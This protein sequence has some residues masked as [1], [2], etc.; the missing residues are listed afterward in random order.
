M[1]SGKVYADVLSIQ[2]TPLVVDSAQFV[3]QPSGVSK[4]NNVFT[5]WQ[6]LADDYNLWKTRVAAPG[7]SGSNKATIVF[8]DTYAPISIPTLAGLADLDFASGTFFESIKASAEGS[9]STPVSI[10][11]GVVWNIEIDS[12]A[13]ARFRSQKITW[14]RE[15]PGAATWLRAPNPAMTAFEMLIQ[16]GGLTSASSSPVYTSPPGK[17]LVVSLRESTLAS[18]GSA[19]PL[20]AAAGAS[21]SLSALQQSSVKVGALSS[22]GPISAL[23]SILDASSQAGPQSTLV[24]PDN[25]ELNGPAAS[26]NVRPGP[27]MS[28]LS[29]LQLS[30]YGAT[31]I[32]QILQAMAV[33]FANNPLDG[34]TLVIT[35]GT[36]VETFTF[37][38]A[39]GGPFEVQIGGSLLLTLANLVTQ[40]NADSVPWK[41]DFFDNPQSTTN[42]AVIIRRTQTVET[43]PDRVYGT[44]GVAVGPVV[45]D[46]VRSDGTVL[47]TYSVSSLVSIPSSDP[48][49]SYAGFS[50]V[51]P[52]L[53]AALVT[54]LNGRND[55]VYQA[56][57]PLVSGSG[58]WVY[59]SSPVDS[60]LL[61]S[62]AGL[63][64]ANR[65]TRL[66]VATLAGAVASTVVLQSGIFPVSVP[67]CIRRTDADGASTLTILPTSG[68]IDG[69][70]SVPQAVTSGRIICF[71]GTN[72]HTVGNA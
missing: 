48:G 28:V 9:S 16:G 55:G 60:P 49:E 29:A 26:N 65:Q 42:A 33:S 45:T 34:N 31:N 8:D 40:I 36:T 10:Q 63:H 41:S 39:A 21:V 44:F 19:P 58:R 5:D 38:L 20:R 2:G 37:L 62:A 23:S 22:P 11:D 35:D 67:L 30:T 69:L 56:Q 59:I 12:D 64:L 53:D 68:T 50:T 17:A 47:L 32:P 72:W 13:V 18:T 70:A 51:S 46:Y 15:A 14:Q 52:L 43:Y 66:V 71:D 61:I 54:V 25:V 24:L 3:F 1:S 4:G 7:Y 6:S 27:G 57:N